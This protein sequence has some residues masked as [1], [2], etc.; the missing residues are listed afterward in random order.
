MA[1]LPYKVYKLLEEEVG[2][3]KT[4]IREK[5][6]KELATKGDIARVRA[7]LAMLKAEVTT[8]IAE[9]KAEFANVRAEIRLMKIW[10]IIL[11]L[12]V[13]FF[14][15]EALGVLLEIIKLLR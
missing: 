1:L 11:T 9:V 10:L 15:R 14:N 8:E 5:L 7:E 2:K 13:A 4:E 12:G 6:S 3:E